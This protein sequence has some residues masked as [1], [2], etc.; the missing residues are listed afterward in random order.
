MKL[1]IYALAAVLVASL[2]LH[3]A[4][5]IP[6]VV[7]SELDVGQNTFFWNTT[8]HVNPMVSQASVSLADVPVAVSDEKDCGDYLSE[9][10]FDA[11]SAYD[12]VS[13]ESIR[14]TSEAPGLSVIIR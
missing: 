8:K 11:R 1:N 12:T 3:A 9:N 5:E 10:S 7:F 2:A 14:F 6:S 4:E 13:S